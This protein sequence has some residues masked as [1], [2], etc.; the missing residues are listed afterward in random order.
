MNRHRVLALAMGALVVTGVPAARA[1]TEDVTEGA[2]SFSPGQVDISVGDRVVWT[3]KSNNAHTVTFQNGPDLHQ[4]CTQGLLGP[5]GNCQDPGTTAQYT[6]NN[7][8][9]FA[10]Y[11]KLHRSQGMAGVVVVSAASTTSTTA[12]R[13]STTTTTRPATTTTRLATSSTT[14]TTRPLATSSTLEDSSTTTTRADGTSVLLPGDAPPMGGEGANSAADS[15]GSDDGGD[16]ATVA[17]IV[18]LLLVVSAGGGYLLW[19]LR[20]SRA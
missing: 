8:G 3:N 4:T 15:G 18:A 10:Y 6:F 14:A 17:L 12:A 20:P 1:A 13:S 16:T 5:V 7:A 2:T 9:T 19:R 11:C